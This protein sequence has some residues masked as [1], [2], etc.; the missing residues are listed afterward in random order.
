M[1][2]R[3]LA[4]AGLVLC[5]AAAVAAP[6]A[7]A[8]KPARSAAASGTSA[9][10]GTAGTAQDVPPVTLL[11]S[12]GGKGAGGKALD[13]VFAQLQ[14]PRMACTFSEEKQVA[15]LARPLRSSGTLLFDRERGV[16]RATVK[17]RPS[18]VLLTPTALRI[19]KGGKTEEIALD[20]SKDL[21]AFVLVFPAL[22]RGDRAQLERSFELRLFG[23]GQD[24]WALRLSPRAKSL[25]SL[26]SRV[27]VVGHE[28]QLVSLEVTEAS[29]DVTRTRLSELRV[30]EQVTD[31]EIAA[32]FGA[33]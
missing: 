13:P 5:C 26:V 25:R 7:P 6:A 30:G 24:W 16:F 1:T 4:G 10:A 14:L 17:P 31:D 11:A 3:L 29:G 20:K 27:V 32:A 9:T 19:T 21:R 33:R 12:V 2:L 28:H 15:L 18:Q 8:A 22:L 23:R